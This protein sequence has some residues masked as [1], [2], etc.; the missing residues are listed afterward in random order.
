MIFSK[1]NSISEFNKLNHCIDASKRFGE[2]SV[3]DA[4]TLIFFLEIVKEALIA[5]RVINA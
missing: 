1:E 4:E 5:R 3:D 2:I